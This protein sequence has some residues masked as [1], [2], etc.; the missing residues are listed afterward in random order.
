MYNKYRFH[1]P[2]EFDVHVQPSSNGKQRV[3]TVVGPNG[4]IGRGMRQPRAQDGPNQV[5]SVVELHVEGRQGGEGGGEARGQS[6][7]GKIN[8]AGKVQFGKT[9][10][11]VYIE[12]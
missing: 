6:T 1:V 4:P 11:E 3:T 7:T 9:V 2:G 5:P 10:I 12:V 8:T